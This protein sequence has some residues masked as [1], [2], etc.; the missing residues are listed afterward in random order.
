MPSSDNAAAYRSKVSL[1]EGEAPAILRTAPESPAAVPME[2][3]NRSDVV[4]PADN[5]IRTGEAPVALGIIWTRAGDNERLLEQRVQLPFSLHPG[6]RLLLAP[7]LDPASLPAGMYN[8]RIA[9]VHEHVTWFDG[10]GGPL[11]DIP[12]TI[13][14]RQ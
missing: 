13:G 10:K 12:V 6:E 5:D 1:L 2:I 8:V 11:I 9:L 14:A 4:W 3:V 7:P